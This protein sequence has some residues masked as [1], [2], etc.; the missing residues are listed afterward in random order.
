[1]Q[2]VS[3]VPDNKLVDVPTSRKVVTLHL[4]RHLKIRGVKGDFVNCSVQMRLPGGHGSEYL[5]AL[6][7]DSKHVDTWL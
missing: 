2:F 3:I 5:R 7:S 1:M 6:G 4:Q